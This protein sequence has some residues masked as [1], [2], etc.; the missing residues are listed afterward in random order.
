M[1]L[2]NEINPEKSIYYY[3]SRLLKIVK[4]SGEAY[5]IVDLYNLMKKSLH[6]SLKNFSY[7]LDWLFLIEAVKVTEEGRVILCT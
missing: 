4:N 2:P 6:I 5:N 3:A 1:L 7:S